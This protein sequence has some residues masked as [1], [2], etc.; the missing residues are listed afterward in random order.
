[1]NPS[2]SPVTLSLAA[3]GSGAPVATTPRLAW[4]FSAPG[5][6]LSAI[7]PALNGGPTPLRINEDG[8][9]PPMPGLFTPA[10]GPQDITLPP[11]SQVFVVLLDA[12]APA[13]T[14]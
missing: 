6:N 11:M 13:C 7:G 10:D 1:V 5:G 3:A 12:H 14:G 9:L 8:S 4:A 2:T